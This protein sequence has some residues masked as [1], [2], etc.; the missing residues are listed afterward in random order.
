MKFSSLDG[1]NP[2]TPNYSAVILLAPAMLYSN[3]ET[4]ILGEYISSGGKLIICGEAGGYGVND[5]LNTLSDD[6]GLGIGFNLDVVVD[7]GLGHYYNSYYSP[8]I[9][10]F[11]PHPTTEGLED[12]V[13][14]D[15]S[16]SLSVDPTH[17]MAIA[18]ASSSAYTEPQVP[19]SRNL[20]NGNI[21]VSAV[22]EISQGKVVVIGDANVFV[23]SCINLFANMRFFENI[24]NW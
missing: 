21:I 16:C 5:K 10:D 3:T 8:I 17:S 15:N 12:N 22:T 20:K 6:L 18:Y 2:S 4:Q 7:N 9:S 14:L 1:F 19:T 11:V 24:I 23:D 13:V